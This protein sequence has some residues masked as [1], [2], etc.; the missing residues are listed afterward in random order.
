MSA[1]KVDHNRK[2]QISI[3]DEIAY[4]ST[5]DAHKLEKIQMLSEIDKFAKAGIRDTKNVYL[6][7]D[8][9][10]IRQSYNQLKQRYETHKKN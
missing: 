3:G 7:S 6:N 10:E 4:D 2:V 8:I 1:R 5:Q 9:E